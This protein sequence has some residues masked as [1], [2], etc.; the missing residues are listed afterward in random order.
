MLSISPT[1]S[2]FSG[3]CMVTSERIAQSKDRYKMEAG[4]LSFHLLLVTL[5]TPAEPREEPVLFTNSVSKFLLRCCKP[6]QFH[7]LLA[8]D[9]FSFWGKY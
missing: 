9:E 1:L 5:W 6:K 8:E 4:M 3:G 2:G 7:S